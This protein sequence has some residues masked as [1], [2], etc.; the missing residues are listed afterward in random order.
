MTTKINLPSSISS[1]PTAFVVAYVFATIDSK[2]Y[3]WAITRSVFD[4][5]PWAI[6]DT[7]DGSD[8]SRDYATR[9]EFAILNA[10][11][12]LHH[13]RIVKP[14]IYLVDPPIDFDINWLHGYEFTIL[15]IDP[16]GEITAKD[17]Y[18]PTLYD[19]DEDDSDD[20]DEPTGSGSE[21]VADEEVAPK[22]D[23]RNTTPAATSNGGITQANYA[24]KLHEAER[25][26]EYQATKDTILIKIRELNRIIKANKFGGAK[27]VQA[28]LDKIQWQGRLDSIN[29]DLALA[30]QAK[31]ELKHLEK[32]AKTKQEVAPAI[33]VTT[34][35]E[36]TES[37]VN[38]TDSAW[39][40][41]P[42]PASESQVA[43]PRVTIYHAQLSNSVIATIKGVGLHGNSARIYEIALPK[44][45]YRFA[46]EFGYCR[47]FINT[48]KTGAY[49]T[50]SG[51]ITGALKFLDN[52]GK[53]EFY[54]NHAHLN[55]LPAKWAN[56]DARPVTMFEVG[57]SYI[58]SKGT[59]YTVH[60]RRES[61]EYS[62]S[63]FDPFVWLTNRNQ[64]GH[65]RDISYDNGVEICHWQP[66]SASILRADCPAPTDPT[67][68]GSDEPTGSGNTPAPAPIDWHTV[69]DD[70]AISDFNLIDSSEWA[71]YIS[72]A[73]KEFDAMMETEHAEMQCDDYEA[74]Q[75]IERKKSPPVP[76]FELLATKA[77][78]KAKRAGRAKFVQM[79]GMLFDTPKV[80][81]TDLI[82]RRAAQRKQLGD[83]LPPAPLFRGI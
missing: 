8:N 72:E 82:A 17:V 36:I 25:I 50:I 44:N 38:F 18:L 66:V 33:E 21:P 14:S 74:E 15:E 52:E 31:K 55:L 43:Q 6:T 35:G 10:I 68:D 73:E 23:T 71:D 20:S 58:S 77:L 5:L 70:I 34:Q 11:R 3:S 57:K 4:S 53:L 62:S 2:E 30:K 9:F 24:N 37:D 81:T 47:K 1:Y 69:I 7:S 79:T 13:I 60:A 63:D 26:A 22:L 49:K 54:I 64:R 27:F 16:Q 61:G 28:K 75:E 67:P 29:N 78:A 12:S 51:A 19:S 39:E 45:G 80:S 46:V 59:V 83:R 40:I 32:Q 48:Y 65:R 76:S 42:T 56:A 41:T